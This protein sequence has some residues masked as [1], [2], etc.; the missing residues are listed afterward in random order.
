MNG[1][2]TNV[3][4]FASAIKEA[5]RGNNDETFA[6]LFEIATFNDLQEVDGIFIE[7]CRNGNLHPVEFL[8]N[9]YGESLSISVAIT[10]LCQ[11]KSITPKHVDIFKFL[12]RFSSLSILDCQLLMN[13]ACKY[14]DINIIHWL[15]DFFDPDIF[16]IYS[17]IYHAF[18]THLTTDRELNCVVITMALLHKCQ[19]VSLD[20]QAV[21]EILCHKE[22]ILVMGM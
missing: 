15:L 12:I 19:W 9:K 7:A 16:E 20:I 13:W 2:D 17:A 4:D 18:D 21:M 11:N 3:L 8:H 14:H 10:E 6:Y 22:S 5:L 1:F